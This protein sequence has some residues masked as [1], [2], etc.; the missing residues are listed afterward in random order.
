MSSERPPPSSGGPKRK[1]S[2]PTLVLDITRIISKEARDAFIEN[3]KREEE[4]VETKVPCPTCE[5][6]KDCGGTHTVAPETRSELL[7]KE[8]GLP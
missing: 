8:T 7:R 5:R 2:D 6:C 4:G 1:N 3:L